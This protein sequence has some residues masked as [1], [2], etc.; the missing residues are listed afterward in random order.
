[1]DDLNPRFAGNKLG[2]LQRSTNLNGVTWK[3]FPYLAPFLKSVPVGQ[4]AFAF[5]GLGPEFPLRTPAPEAL[6]SEVVSHTNLVYYDWEMTGPRVLAGIYTS[7]LLRLM[8]QKLQ[9]PADGI[10]L[11]WLKTLGEKLQ[12]CGTEIS[13]SDPKHLSFVRRSSIGL[14]A[15]ELH[16]LVDR[17]ES[18]DFPIGFYTV[19]APETSSPA[20][21][22]PTHAGS[23]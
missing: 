12:N 23:H 14:T 9:L 18:P 8:L 20:G 15:V 22:A 19:L 21:V 2:E 5:G 17:L 13:L 6:I 4:S 10:A 11:I 1:M 7:Q 3:G 16:L